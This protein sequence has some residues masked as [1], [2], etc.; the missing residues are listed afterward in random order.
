MT[1]ILERYV[2]IVGKEQIAQLQ[3]IAHSL[4]GLKIVHINSTKIGGG[5]AEI[6][7]AMVPLT[8]ALGIDTSWE[9]VE[10]DSEYFQCTKSFHNSLQGMHVPIP[11]SLLKH[12]EKIN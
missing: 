10:G 7:T 3:Q 6:L 2:E 9:I 5:V 1:N 12:Y 11:D 8:N 4:N